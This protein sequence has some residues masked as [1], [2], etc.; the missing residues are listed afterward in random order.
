MESGR[1]RV[2]IVA[3]DY[4]FL[5]TLYGAGPAIVHEWHVANSLQCLR[6]LADP[7]PLAVVIDLEAPG[8]DSVQ[9][10]ELLANLHIAARVVL[11]KGGDMRKLSNALR[12]ATALALDVAGTLERP[13]MMSDLSTLLARHVAASTPIAGEEVAQAI[14]RRELLLHY[15]PILA[16]RRSR[17]VIRGVEALIR[18]QHPRRGLLY[19]G[20]FLKVAE[21]AGQLPALTDFV[22]DAAV[23]QAGLWQKLGL[24]LTMA[25]N[26][27]PTVVRDGG[28]LDRFMQTLREHRVAPEH[29]TLEVIEAASLKDRELVRDVLSRL[30]LHGV[31]LSLDDFGTGYSSL[32][33]LCRLPFNEI[34][35][36]R[37][38]I[39]DVP[40][41]RE[42]STIVSAIVGLAHRLSMRVCAEGVESHA[43]F[44]YLAEAGCDSMQGVLFAQ[45]MSA[46]DLEQLVARGEDRTPAGATTG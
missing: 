16:R 4:Q 25:I 38:L 39:H 45:P 42:A 23:R 35:I 9:A 28:F 31:A 37:A 6:D 12:A 34:K 24:E 13:L 3:E 29:I 18:W 5:D 14:S 1:N 2:L 27:A 8:I 32:T 33:E 10:L 43:A 36:D 30:R 17:W 19:P 40:A 46:G 26:L 44:E 20:Q 15:Q 22:F 7:P 41:V 21:G 11:L